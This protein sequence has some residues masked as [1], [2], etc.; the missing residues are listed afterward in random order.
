MRLGRPCAPGAKVRNKTTVAALKVKSGQLDLNRV[1]ARPPALQYPHESL[2]TQSLSAHPRSRF[3][4]GCTLYACYHRLMNGHHLPE[5]EYTIIQ[6]FQGRGKRFHLVPVRGVRYSDRR[7]PPYPGR[8]SRCGIRGNRAPSR[9][10]QVGGGQAVG[11]PADERRDPHPLCDRVG[12]PAGG[13]SNCCSLLVYDEELRKLA[14]LA[15]RGTRSRAEM[16]LQ[17]TAL[18]HEAYL[19]LVDSD[20]GADLGQAGATSSPRRPRP[21][22]ADPRR[23]RPGARRR[24]KASAASSDGKAR[25][26]T[27]MPWS[28]R[29]FGDGS[30]RPRRR[31]GSARPAAIRR[32]P[33]LRRAAL[34][35][36]GLTG[37]QAAAVLGDLPQQRC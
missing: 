8:L 10:R 1:G 23:E 20:P 2:R 27:S 37:D 32:R 17:A 5:T 28:H 14:A 13:R 12:R 3:A 18:V 11:H 35:S 4:A 31:P 15:A 34:T 21:C 26:W 9:R 29:D 36:A 22:A 7:S 25:T 33:G 19:R 30:A 24:R 6:R 16:T